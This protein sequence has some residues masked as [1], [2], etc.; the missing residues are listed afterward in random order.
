MGFTA[1]ESDKR[2]YI[3]GNDV[4]SRNWLIFPA[5]A[6]IVVCRESL[7][8]SFTYELL[9]MVGA[10]QVANCAP[11]QQSLAFAIDV[12]LSDAWRSLSFWLQWPWNPSSFCGFPNT[13]LQLHQG[14]PNWG[15]VG[16]KLT[17]KA[18][19]CRRST[20]ALLFIFLLSSQRTSSSWWRWSFSWFYT[21]CKH[22]SF[23]IC[24]FVNPFQH[25]RMLLVLCAAEWVP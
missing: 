17:A 11:H 16:S 10:C 18:V 1:C 25:S 5:L 3:G 4:C 8:P 22:F 13:S 19:D 14:K 24:P 9:N 6:G 12:I 2:L 15:A 23:K 7:A 20:W 21:W